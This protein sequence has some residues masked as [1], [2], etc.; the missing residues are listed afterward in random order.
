MQFS[1]KLLGDFGVANDGII[2][3]YFQLFVVPEEDNMPSLLVFMAK[4]P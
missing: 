1:D 3:I 2:R 4:N